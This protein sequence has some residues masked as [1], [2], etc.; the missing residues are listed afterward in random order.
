MADPASTPPPD[1][2]E[3]RH[4]IKER[5]ATLP[6]RLTQLADFVMSSP[7]DFALGTVSSVASHAG[8]QPS[9]VIRFA[10]LF[11]FAGFSDMQDVFR[12]RLR[13][14]PHTYRDRIDAL[15]QAD[16]RLPSV[17][18]LL[19]GF[20]DAFEAS[21]RTMRLH[22]EGD[23]LERAVE[24][25]SSSE[26]V[27]LLGM[28]RSAAVVEYFSYL[29]GKLGVKNI[30]VG[31]ATN[32][33]TEI[34]SF[35]TGRDAAFIISNTPYAPRTIDLF[36]QFEAQGTR[37]VVLTDSPFSAVV[38]ADGVWFELIEADFKGFRANS[39][40]MVLIMTLA[41]AIGERRQY[42]ADSQKSDRSRTRT[43]A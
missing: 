12:A 4:L 33:E 25:L 39:A 30:V 36:A 41:A 22:M 9:T 16:G 23:R 38:P 14:R 42:P 5:Y 43:T 17:M 6:R 11:G 32:M 7:D 20:S 2:D 28:R 24:I 21:L 13:G 34:V 8:V 37:L 27:Y 19:D 40:G 3:F 31:S 26:T 15:R 18:T 1:F 35:A 29:L 10:R